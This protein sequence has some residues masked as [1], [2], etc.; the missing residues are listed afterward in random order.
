MSC[1]I[2]MKIVIDCRVARFKTVFS[3]FFV[4]T[5]ARGW[6]LYLYVFILGDDEKEKCFLFAK[7]E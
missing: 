5:V 7:M 6:S 2:K 4:V 3:F 1:E